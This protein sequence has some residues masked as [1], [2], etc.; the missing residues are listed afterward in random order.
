MCVCVCYTHSTSTLSVDLL[1]VSGCFHVLV[2]VNSAAMNVGVH[3]SF[4]ISVFV[5]LDICMPRSGTAGSY[6]RS[7]FSF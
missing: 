4:Q 2:I 1:M 7:V 6:G 5:F 3:V